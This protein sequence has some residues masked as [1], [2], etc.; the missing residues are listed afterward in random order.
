MRLIPFERETMVLPADGATVMAFVRQKT[1]TTAEEATGRVFKGV[2]G[3]DT[4]TVTLRVTR[5]QIMIPQVRGEVADTSTGCILFLTYRF[6]PN[7][8]FFLAFWTVV[9]FLLALVFLG[10]AGNYLYGC[11]AL[12][13]CIGNY[14][15]ALANFSIHRKQI[16]A[17]L[18]GVLSSEF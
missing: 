6:F 15:V 1:Q 13:F 16:K 17:A 11:L 12:A 8:N 7:T 3:P 18:E 4:F 2:V 10:P 14:A 9:S 5:A